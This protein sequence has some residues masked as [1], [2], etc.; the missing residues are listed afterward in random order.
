MNCPKITSMVPLLEMNGPSRSSFPSVD[1]NAV[2]P[3]LSKLPEPD[4]PPVKL[5][6]DV[7]LLYAD[8]EQVMEVIGELSLPTDVPYYTPIGFNPAYPI[9]MNGYRSI[10]IYQRPFCEVEHWNSIMIIERC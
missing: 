1:P 2:L 4:K 8:R 6:L 5:V 10:R 9:L 7:A 3:I